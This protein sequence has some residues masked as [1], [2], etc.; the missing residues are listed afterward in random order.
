MDFALGYGKGKLPVRV[1]DA[2][3]AAVLVP[4]PAGG[5]GEPGQLIRDALA[6]PIGS[7]RLGEIVGPGE[8]VAVITSDITR[9]MPSRTVLPF[10]LEELGQAG[11]RDSDITVVFG[12]GIHRGHTGEE[13]RRLAGEA[14]HARVRCLDSNPDRVVRLGRTS[15]NGTPVD[16]F[17]EVA[18]ADRRLCLGNIEYHYFAGY[19]GGGKA[20]MP[21]VSTRAA[22]QANHSLMTRPGAAAGRL[23]GNPVRADLDQAA[24]MAGVDFILNVILDEGKNIVQ[25]VAG[26]LV[27]AHREGCRRLDAM[28]KAAIDRPADIVLVSAGGFP[29]DIN[30]Y[31]AQKALDNAKTAVRDGGIIILAAAC[32]E[33][34]GEEVFERWMAG[35]GSSAQMITD[36]QR[37]FELGGHKAAAIAMVM[38]RARVFLVSDLEPGF[39]R[40][41]FFT[42]QPD[43][44]T[45]LAEAFRELGPD[46]K[47][48]VMPHG[49]STLPFYADF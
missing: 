7:P 42:P 6:Q 18:G 30:L 3:L 28:Y 17:D 31:Q 36:I 5:T 26:D 33:G 37:N 25:A 14:V 43:L 21:G 9:P 34:L 45:A 16:V 29:K 15:P 20:I 48:I 19:S 27:K 22:I 4:N 40:S 38:E 1:G 39:A 24:G 32:G 11:I 8:R 46:S 44:E 2:N 41:I 10:I 23:D 13:R 49:G 12:L 35:A 47:V